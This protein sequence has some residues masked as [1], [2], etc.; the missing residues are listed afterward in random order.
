M[1]MIIFK[2]N[3]NISICITISFKLA[4]LL[5]L[6]RARLFLEDF[7]SL[8]FPLWVIIIP[9]RLGPHCAYSAITGFVSRNN[10]IITSD[11]LWWGRTLLTIIIIMTLVERLMCV[12]VSVPLFCFSASALSLIFILYVSY[13]DKIPHHNFYYINSSVIVIVIVML[14][15]IMIIL[16]LKL[17][18]ILISMSVTLTLS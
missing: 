2:I 9:I 18:T 14:C 17:I 11:Y 5:S 7:D 6:K 16:L 15:I 3:N 10:I 1:I 4:R 12:T 13:F 8:D